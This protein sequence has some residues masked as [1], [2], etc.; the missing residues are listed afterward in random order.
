MAREEKKMV[1]RAFTV[2]T[3]EGEDPFWLEIGASFDHKDGKGLTVA[4]QAL[5]QLLTV[6]RG[7]KDDVSSAPNTNMVLRTKDEAW[8]PVNLT[9]SRLHLSP[10]TLGLIIARRLGVSHA[11]AIKT[12]ARLKR[13]GLA[14]ARPYRGVQAGEAVGLAG[15]S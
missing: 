2:I 10:K 15:G 8:V 13:A 11:T 1:H 5:P 14:T 6:G 4:L 7:F 3:R 9:V 12:I